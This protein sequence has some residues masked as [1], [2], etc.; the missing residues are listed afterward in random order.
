MFVAPPGFRHEAALRPEVIGVAY[1]GTPGAR[2]ALRYA[3]GLAADLD[4]T[5]R[6]L[7]VHPPR[8]EHPRGGPHDVPALQARARADAEEIVGG[9][10]A[11][12]LAERQGHPATELVLATEDELGLLV[13]GSRGHGPLLR[14]LL[15]SVSAAVLRSSRAPVVVTTG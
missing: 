1:D 5:L 6:V 8:R 3:A 13:V 10:V 14:V 9:R 11:I 12:E 15:G 4:M 7:T 2:A